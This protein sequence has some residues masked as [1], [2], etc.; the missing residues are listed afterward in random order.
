MS[1]DFCEFVTKNTNASR[2]VMV[3]DDD[4]QDCHDG[5]ISR[6]GLGLKTIR[7][8]CGSHSE[9]HSCLFYPLS[10]NIDGIVAQVLADMKRLSPEEDKTFYILIDLYL[11]KDKT[12]GE[13]IG[14]QVYKALSAEM[15]RIANRKAHYAYFTMGG[16]DMDNLNDHDIP[17]FCKISN[18]G[19][20]ESSLTDWLGMYTDLDWFLNPPGIDCNVETE[21]F[22]DHGLIKAHWPGSQ[23][24][25]KHR[26]SVRRQFKTQ[27][28]DA[29]WDEGS[30]KALLYSTENKIVA[31]P[32]GGDRSFMAHLLRPMF[33]NAEIERGIVEIRLPA[34][35]AFP[36]LLAVRNF[37]EVAAW[38]GHDSME[39]R[40][41]PPRYQL[42]R[43]GTGL[44]LGIVQEKD[45][46]PLIQAFRAIKNN[47]GVVVHSTT[48]ALADAVRARVRADRIDNAFKRTL[49]SGTPDEIA[50]PLA[51]KLDGGQY[52][53]GIAWLEK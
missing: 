39:A 40:I 22:G 2:V 50:Q 14:P 16:G 15:S 45:P 24:Y 34:A 36:F 43:Q 47:P 41:L 18:R 9:T 4:Y 31:Y 7:N 6:S 11:D 5:H 26:Q 17:L 51:L 49:I 20:L 27:D 23:D 37:L 3:I 10:L 28:D 46:A 38:D 19:K 35:P 25:E 1:I 21:W 13:V 53:L 30:V 12:H 42:R 33:P 48:Q 29:D 8:Q 44:A 52:F 32:G